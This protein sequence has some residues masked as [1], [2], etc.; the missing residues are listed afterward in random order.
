MAAARSNFELVKHTFS[1]F[2]DDECPRMAAALSYYMIFSLPSLLILILLIVGAIFDP[3]DVRGA[4]QGQIESL[5][6]PGG[7]Q[8]VETMLEHAQRPDMGAPL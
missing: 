7:A 5:M 4:L 8:E 1:E 3:A 6:G 2:L